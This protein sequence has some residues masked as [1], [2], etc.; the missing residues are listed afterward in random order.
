VCC[1][2]AVYCVTCVSFVLCLIV[3]E[4]PQCKTQF[5]VKINNDNNNF[6]GLRMGERPPAME[7]SCEYI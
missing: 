5:A 6:L 2:V 4:L 7:G 1:L 3:V